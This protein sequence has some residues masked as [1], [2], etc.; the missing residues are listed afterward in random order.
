MQPRPR[1]PA[2]ADS[3]RSSESSHHL[4]KGYR[5]LLGSLAYVR[6][7]HANGGIIRNVSD[8]GL[9]IQAVGRLHTGQ[10]IHL[11]F[12][13]LKPKVRVEAT[14][15]VAWADADGQ[16]GIRFLDVPA[17][18]RRLLKD[19]LLTDLLASASELSPACAPIFAGDAIQRA[20]EEDGLL[21]SG[22]ALPAIRL[23]D[24]PVVASAASNPNAAPDQNV[25][26]PLRLSWWP[27]DISP[28]T[29]AIFVDSLVVMS[30]VLL[31]WIIFVATVG[32]FLPWIVGV[33][34]GVAVSAVFALMYRYLFLTFSG[35]TL[36]RRLAQLAAEDMH[37]LTEPDEDAPR[38]R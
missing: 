8:S 10:V 13:L 7:D 22:A 25:E 31:F 5:H 20:E 14:G 1:P 6:I 37:W 12:E 27:A 24:N 29:L 16:A 38:F 19:W 34:L 26:M 32:I 15:Q 2:P 23:E 4:R 21:L 30:S 33:A 9:A 36:G 35:A 3:R 28:R 18:S 17:R 11:R